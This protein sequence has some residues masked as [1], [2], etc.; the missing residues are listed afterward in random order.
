MTVGG[1]LLQ[2]V[3]SIILV[4]GPASILKKDRLYV[5]LVLTFVAIF[6]CCKLAG[7]LLAV[8]VTVVL[9]LY[10]MWIRFLAQST[11]GPKYILFWTTAILAGVY[12]AIQIIHLPIRLALGQSA[13]L[14]AANL[15]GIAWALCLLC[16]PVELAIVRRH[17]TRSDPEADFAIILEPGDPDLVSSGS[18]ATSPQLPKEVSNEECPYCERIVRPDS[19]G[20][21]PAC[22]RPI[23]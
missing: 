23:A 13:L 14:V 7:L 8:P 15:I 12:L 5:S 11:S 10:F 2:V 16:A 21:C 17:R 22:H 3:F 18:N 20:R 9:L 6:G 4:C 19:E 1:T